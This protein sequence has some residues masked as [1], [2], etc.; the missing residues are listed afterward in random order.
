M[1]NDHI[2]QHILSHIQDESP[3]EI[4]GLIIVFSGRQLYIRCKNIAENPSI[5]F[6]IDPI[7]WKNAEDRGQILAVVHSHPGDVTP[8]DR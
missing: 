5:N 6:E 1:I 2:R 4:C 3:N 7:E 8:S